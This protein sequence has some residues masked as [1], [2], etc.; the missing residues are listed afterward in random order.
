MI[1]FLHTVPSYVNLSFSSI[2]CKLVHHLILGTLCML[3]HDLLIGTWCML[4]HDLL[5]GTLCMWIHDLL[6]GLV[7]V[8]IKLLFYPFNSTHI[9]TLP[10]RVSWPVYLTTFFFFVAVVSHMAHK[11]HFY[12]FYDSNSNP[13]SLQMAPPSTSLPIFNIQKKKFCHSGTRAQ[14]LSLIV[15]SWDHFATT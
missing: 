9:S 3:I 15:S 13:I 14:W 5:L 10:L 6:S 7:F 1:N 12:L 4:I 2:W 11:K 8:V